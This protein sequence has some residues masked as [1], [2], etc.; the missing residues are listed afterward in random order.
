[1]TV[2]SG[3]PSRQILAAALA[4]AHPEA[5]RSGSITRVRFSQAVDV[6]YYGLTDEERNWKRSVR[7]TRRDPLPLPLQPFAPNPILALPPVSTAELPHEPDHV[8]IS[9]RAVPGRPFVLHREPVATSQ[10]PVWD[11]AF[12][13]IWGL[14]RRLESIM[15]FGGFV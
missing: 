11:G 6:Q 13:A 5:S 14:G 1:M 4:A 15:C 3:S 7:Q 8:S 2:A 12:S 10:T 9:I